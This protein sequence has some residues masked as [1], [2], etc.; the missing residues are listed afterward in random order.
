MIEE[1]GRLRGKVALVTGAAS[2]IGAE[3]AQRL[4]EEGAAV[5]VTDREVDKGA[6]VA[7]NITRLGGRAIFFHLNVTDESDW[8]RVVADALD[9]FG[10]LDVL[11]NNA[12]VP[13][14]GEELM[15]HS[16]EAW[17]R[18]LSINLDGVF[19][20]LRY[21][22]P[23]IAQGGGGSVIN[24][25]SIMGKVAT[26]GAAAYCASKGG[27]TLLTKA[28][29]LEWA[30]MR[31]RV[32]S[33][34][35]GFIDTPMVPGAADPTEQAQSVRKQIISRHPLG[36]FGTA[37]DVADGVVFLASDESGFMTGSELV[38]DGGYTAQ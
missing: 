4:A 10:R 7:A 26:A 9:K 19:L 20:G 15:T 2:G 21:S 29:S 30:P 18:T 6:A 38:I 34:H 28:A 12:G 5:V 31:I 33:I 24:M 16:F 27:V 13:P 37:R 8:A 25:S 22:G 3:S 36:R 14:C 11:V 23:V 17:R 35:P 1:R 32:N